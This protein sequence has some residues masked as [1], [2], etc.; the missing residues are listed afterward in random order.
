MEYDCALSRANPAFSP[1]HF[2]HREVTLSDMY[3]FVNELTVDV[4][5]EEDVLPESTQH[6]SIM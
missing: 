4:C 5:I 2:I 1:Q 6:V 3:P